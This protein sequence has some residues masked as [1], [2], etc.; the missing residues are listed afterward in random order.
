M[1][2]ERKEHQDL[3]EELRCIA[4]FQQIRGKGKDIGDPLE[5]FVVTRSPLKYFCWL[6]SF[7]ALNFSEVCYVTGIPELI[8]IAESGLIYYVIEFAEVFYLAGA[9][10][11]RIDGNIG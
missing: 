10:M 6:I 2:G 9:T 8:L 1:G 11:E 5:I 4:S 7:N 3:V